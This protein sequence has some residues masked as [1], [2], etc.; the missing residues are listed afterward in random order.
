MNAIFSIDGATHSASQLGI[1]DAKIVKRCSGVDELKLS[2][3]S[4]EF[5]ENFPINNTIEVYVNSVKK[6]SGRII[7]TPITLAGKAQSAS[8]IAYN[9]WNDLEQIV[10]Q[11]EWVRVANNTVGNFY[12]SKVVLGQ[13][14]Y[15]EKINVGEQIRDI[16]EYAIKCGA[17]FKIG[18]IDIDAPMLLDE[19]RDL[20]CSQSILRV[21]KWAPNAF[22]FFDYSSDSIP[23]L[24]VQKSTSLKKIN[25]DNSIDSILKVS[26]TP[27]PDLSLDGVSVKYEQEN[28]INSKST[29]T[30][31]ED[32][33]PAK[34]S[35]TF[36]KIL[37]MSVDLDGR[38]ASC[39]NY[40][41]VCENIDLESAHWWAKHIPSLPEAD[42]EIL[43]TSITEGSFSRELIEGSIPSSL[44]FKKQSAIAKAKI[45]YLKDDGTI[46]TKN[47]ATRILTTTAQTGTYSVWRTSQYAE[48]KPTGLA[49]AIYEASARLL[50]EG[51][52]EIANALENDF[53]GKLISI[54][55]PN[56]SD[57]LTINSPIIF[58]EENIAKE[59]T[60]IKIGTPN[61]LYPDKIAELFR[62]SRNRKITESSFLRTSPE[63]NFTINDMTAQQPLD[64]GS[65]GDT[66]YQRLL[67]SKIESEESAKK[68]DIN[69][70]DI[71][72][73]ETAQMT[74]IYLCHNG[75]LASAKILMTEPIIEDEF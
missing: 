64:N 71:G 58:V 48:P 56:H 12:R 31:F 46:C 7:K 2:L 30:I 43:E 5:V 38:K 68:I 53:I 28:I 16:A 13:N 55:I 11:Q 33:Y 10:Y 69:S 65:E 17:N 14:K 22:A 3:A 1:V 20:S 74:Q 8:I 23:I 66:N 25:L 40:K 6:F 21:L 9:A 61:H 57:W 39:H 75:F 49:K 35:P 36:P 41:I 73:N 32:N 63:N 62:I 34:I 50:Y 29:L 44:D 26:I 45:R 54:N 37:V 47:V 4:P 60:S 51:S 52:V 24:N 70:D 27:R 72:E 18:K 67:I 59:K 15:A 19:T 42:I